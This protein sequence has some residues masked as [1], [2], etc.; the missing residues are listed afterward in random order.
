MTGDVANVDV[1]RVHDDAGVRKLARDPLEDLYAATAGHLVVENDHIRHEFL[2]GANSLLGITRH[3]DAV[4]IAL[5]VH[6][7]AEVLADRRMIVDDEDSN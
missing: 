3:A 4:H 6:E 2:A 5:G 7:V 1:Q